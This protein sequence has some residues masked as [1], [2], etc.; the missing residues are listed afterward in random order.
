M[1]YFQL[2]LKQM[3]QR[4]LSTWLTTLSVMLGVG[5]AIAIMVLGRESQSLFGQNSFGYDAIIGKKGSPLQLVMNTV[6]HIDLSPGNIPY[7]QYTRLM[8]PAEGL[9]T[10]PDNYYNFVRIAV[11]TVVGDTLDGKYRIVG[12]L[13][14]LFGMDDDGKPLPPADVLDFRPG[15]KLQMAQGQVFAGNKFQAIVGSEIPKLTGKGIGSIIQATHGTPI[16]GQA[17]DIHMQKWQVVGVLAP[18]HT[19]IDRVVY[20]PLLSFYTIAEHGA[21]LRAQAKL[22][23]GEKP[24]EIDPD[25]D[26]EGEHLPD[27]NGLQH[28]SNYDF[29][30]RDQTIKLKISPE[31]WEV[32]AILVQSRGG[33]SEPG[34]EFALNN[35]TDVMAV[36]PAAVMREFFDRF[37][38]PMRQMLLVICSLVTIVAAVGIL[39]SIYN[40]VSARLKEIAIL[41]ALGAT[42]QTVLILIC[43]EAA[44]IAALGSILGVIAGHGVNAVGAWYMLRNYG[45]ILTYDSTEVVLEAVYVIGVIALAVVA[46]LVPALKAYRT[47]VATNLVAA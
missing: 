9:P 29:D 35:G 10:P 42:R 11:P 5:L 2:V 24:D 31:I 41:R 25:K 7:D 28:F 32:S 45:E 13:P 26:A 30:T 23:E 15:E 14:K 17:P 20:I 21:G 8:K 43:L 6:Y 4:S 40:S 46:G 1:N 33:N 18:T 47:S 37:L 34:L 16:P 3:R 27:A 44:A 12:T 19:A 38:S 22:R 36:N 39:V